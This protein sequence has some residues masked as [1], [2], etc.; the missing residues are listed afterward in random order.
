MNMPIRIPEAS[1]EP[2][3]P[4]NGTEGLMFMEQFCDRC[5]K[6]AYNHETG[7]GGCEIQLRTMIHQ[8]GDKDYPSEWVFDASGRPTCTAFESRRHPARK[9]TPCPDSAKE[10]HRGKRC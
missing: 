4:S 5:T 9:E 1:G 3:Q 10:K 2:Y 7:E 8:P 6:N